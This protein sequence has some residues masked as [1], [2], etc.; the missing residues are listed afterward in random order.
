M[1]RAGILLFIL[2][3][4]RVAS[5]QPAAS[6]PAA[7]PAPST[8]PASVPAAR[9]A[10]APASA[11]AKP[12]AKSPAAKPRAKAP[13]R[14]K[15]KKRDR[16]R[17]RG[18]L[19]VVN[20]GRPGAAGWEV[21]ARAQEHLSGLGADWSR[22]PGVAGHLIG[23]PNPGVLPSG[24]SGRDLGLLLQRV[25]AGGS[26]SGAD[27]WKLGR[28]LGVDYLLLMKIG[29][30]G[31]RARLYSVARQ[32]Y[33]PDELVSGDQR[34]ERLSGYVAAQVRAKPKKKLPI[35]RRRWWVWLI[36]AGLGAVT[37][38]LA[39]SSGDDTKGKLKI[40]VSR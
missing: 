23:R 40:R 4:A 25:R 17:L 35:W 20:L 30:R 26:A 22:Q 15:R 14:A 18:T 32:H 12:R 19:A 27:L 28:L 37:I 3:A 38:G 8:A 24:E 34:V 11:P 6:K 10:S 31:M 13:A 21:A 9:P 7:P 16:S 2:L 39:L 1:Y 33:S 36:A 29:R 5:A